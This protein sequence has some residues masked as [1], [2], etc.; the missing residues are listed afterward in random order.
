MTLLAHLAHAQPILGLAEV[1]R[2]ALALA[3]VLAPIGGLLGQVVEP[4]ALAAGV[5]WRL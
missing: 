3:M 4:L 1:D 5:P 2:Q